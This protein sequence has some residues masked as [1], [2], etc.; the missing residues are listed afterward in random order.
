MPQESASFRGAKKKGPDLRLSKTKVEFMNQN[1]NTREYWDALTAGEIE[2][3]YIR[4]N[5]TC[6]KFIEPYLIPGNTFLDLGCNTG[7]FLK[8]LKEKLNKN[9]CDLMGADISEKALK[10]AR[11]DLGVLT[12]TVDFNKENWS[13]QVIDAEVVT[14]F[15]TIEHVENDDLLIRSAYELCSKFLI[16]AIPLND[17]WIEHIR[18]Y[19]VEDVKNLFKNY[20]E[21]KFY[22]SCLPIGVISQEIIVI[23][24]KKQEVRL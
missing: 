19:T 2:R 5:T 4:K 12:F 21:A 7:S 23:I 24:E 10:K 1:I 8:Y 15:H 6:Y 14:C 3:G 20:P 22:K 11:E 17:E 18:S 16:F 9:T 13:D